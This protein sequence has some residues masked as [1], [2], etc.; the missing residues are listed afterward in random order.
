VNANIDLV[1]MVGS[2]ERELWAVDII[3][4]RENLEERT[5]FSTFTRSAMG[6][7]MVVVQE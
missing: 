7:M 4:R 1:G 6:M 3:Y 2:V 5:C